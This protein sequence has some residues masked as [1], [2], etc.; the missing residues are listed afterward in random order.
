MA[1]KSKKKGEILSALQMSKVLGR[2]RMTLTRW[3]QEEGCPYEDCPDE[4]GAGEWKF[5]SA[6]VIDWFIEREVKKAVDNLTP[7]PTPADDVNPDEMTEAQADAMK[8]RW[9]AYKAKSSALLQEVKLQQETGSVIEIDQV[10][11]IV[12]T[13]LVKVRQRLLEMDSQISARIP[14]PDD[15]VM[16][17]REIR[18]GVNEALANIV[19]LEDEFVAPGSE[20]PDD[21]VSEDG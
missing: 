18:G 13:R 3:A 6:L 5:P 9:D 2:D 19:G 21:E 16:V 20:L 17:A 15:R 8:A 12:S 1:R 11:A 10:A 14:N 7:A 4:N